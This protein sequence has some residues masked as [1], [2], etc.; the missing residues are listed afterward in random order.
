[1]VCERRFWR[2]GRQFHQYR[3]SNDDGESW[4]PAE[5]LVTT[6]FLNIS[7]L[8]RNPPIALADGGL[9][10]PI[11]QEFITKRAEWLRISAQGHILGKARMPGAS[12]GLQ[13]TVAAIDGQHA[14]ALLRVADKRFG[15]IMAASSS[16]GGATWLE[17]AP[18]PIGNF[19]SS[20][21]LLRLADGRLLVAANPSDSRSLLQ[22][23][24]SNDAGRSWEPSRIIANDPD[25][26]VEYS[27]PTLLQT[28]DG[29]VHMT[30]TYRRQTI[31]HAVFSE[32]WL[33]G[34][35]P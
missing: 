14:L 21:A 20:V 17:L 29:R 10:L 34:A 19:D 26:H 22:L 30:F 32:A 28:R 12:P 31:A 4:S 35:E 2:L 16:D 18:L 23:F 5:K 25:T 33:N 9:G 13:P 6:P 27:Y 8:V 11:Y 24:V 1:M 15:H 7:T 3:V